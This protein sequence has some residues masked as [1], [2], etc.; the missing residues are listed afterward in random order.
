MAGSF[1]SADYT[2]LTASSTVDCDPNLT[3]SQSL[4]DCSASGGTRTSTLSIQNN[5][6]YDV[7]VVVEY[8]IDSGSWQT[9]GSAEDADDFKVDA[10]QT[11]TS[12]TVTVSEGSTITWRYKDSPT[13]SISGATET[14]LSA[15]DTVDCTASITISQSMGSCSG[16][17][18]TSTLS[19]QN[20]ESYTA[21]MHVEYSLNGG[22]TYI[23][24]PLAKD[25]D[26]FSV[27]A[28]DTN[29]SLTV[30]VSH[31]ETVI[32][33]VT[34]SPVFSSTGASSTSTSESSQVDCPVI[35]ASGSSSFTTVCQNGSRTSTFTMTN[36]DSAN[37]TAYFK[38]EYS[39]NGGTSWTSVLTNQAVTKNSS[40]TV[41]RT[42][43]DGENVQWRYETSTASNTYTGTWTE[44]LSAAGALDCGN[45]TVATSLGSCSAGSATSTFTMTNP[46]TTSVTVYFEVQYQ[47][48]DK[49]GN[50][51]VWTNSVSSQSVSVGG[52]ETATK[53]ISVGEKI[54]WR[55]R[56]SS[57]N[58]T[59]SGSYTETS[60]SSAVS[61]SISTSVSSAFADSC[62]G[63]SKNNTF[64]MNNSG[65]STTAAY[66]LV[67]YSTNNGVSYTEA[68]SSQQ[69][70]IGGSETVT[71]AVPSGSTIKWRYK[72]S[73]FDGSFSGG[74]TTESTSAEVSCGT[75]AASASQA[76]CSSGDANITMSLDNRNQSIVHYFTKHFT[77]KSGADL[78]EM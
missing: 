32:W 53:S 28:G 52:T 29:T 39:L 21:Y 2:T 62:T 56:T 1:G 24:H 34:P 58:G 71:I 41:D 7:Y 69:V 9:H 25:S 48:T 16:G 37:S 18:K 70:A 54:T 22:S 44:T 3:V 67:E 26:N 30:T 19:L 17:S 46:Q 57:E 14:T 31:D 77:T 43:A 5:E 73:Q 20:N 61:C 51:G 72:T 76:T 66:F 60:Q 45:P 13:T 35:D 11:D 64:T 4:G 74:Y 59:F 47:V 27:N 65:S 23:D 49:D 42:V 15:S 8:K 50:D 55:Y 33:R 12:L 68:L 38:V 78:T 36:S 10:G 63:S 40:V 75:P 6:S